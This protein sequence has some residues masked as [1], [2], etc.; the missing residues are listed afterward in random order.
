MTDG[1]SSGFHTLKGY[2]LQ[3]GMEITESMEDYLEMLFRRMPDEG[4]MRVGTLAEQ[5]NVRPSSASKMLG[6]LRALGLTRFEKY[7]LITLTDKGN[8]IGRY[9]LW[10][11]E[12]LSRFFCWLNGTDEELRQVE[13]VEHFMD[14]DTLENL[15][16]LMKQLEKS[17]FCR[18]Q[19]SRRGG[20]GNGEGEAP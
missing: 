4:Y 12:V 7:G 17:G 19:D 10:R 1:A 6:R 3:E 16:R 13:R 5:L 11:H 8:E 18:E 20:R 9:L 15:D 14:R 2:R